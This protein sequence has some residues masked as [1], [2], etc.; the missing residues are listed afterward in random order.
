[1]IQP[2]PKEAR[3]RIWKRTLRTDIIEI[4]H[5]ELLAEEAI[6]S[7]PG[8]VGIEDAADRIMAHLKILIDDYLHEEEEA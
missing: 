3:D 2:K 7:A 1:M 6:D 4:M 8:V 5:D